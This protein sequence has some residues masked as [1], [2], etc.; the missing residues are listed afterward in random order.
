MAAFISSL[1][2]HNDDGLPENLCWFAVTSIVKEHP[3]HNSHPKSSATRTVGSKGIDNSVF[4]KQAIL[5]HG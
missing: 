5:Y 3:K 4:S 2:H 1:G